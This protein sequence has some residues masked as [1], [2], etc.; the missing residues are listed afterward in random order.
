MF[1]FLLPALAA[2]L[3]S[4]AI[5]ACEVKQYFETPYDNVYVV[6][7]DD[8]AVT[9]SFWHP[10]FKRFS[11]LAAILEAGDSAQKVDVHGDLILINPSLTDITKIFSVVAIRRAMGVRGPVS[12]ESCVEALAPAQPR[13]SNRYPKN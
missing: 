4:T 11:P 12:A 6:S 13:A 5:Y 1:K 10:T 2:Q 8:G 3:I 9:L 7:Y